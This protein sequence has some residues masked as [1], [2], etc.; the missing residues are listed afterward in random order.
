MLS[1][2]CPHRRPHVTPSLHISLYLINVFHIPAIPDV[3]EE[4]PLLSLS[5]VPSAVSPSSNPLSS[6]P[7][8]HPR[9]KSSVRM[10]AIPSCIPASRRPWLSPSPPCSLSLIT[11]PQ[12]SAGRTDALPFTRGVYY[13]S[14]TVDGVIVSFAKVAHVSAL[15]VLVCEPSELSRTLSEEQF[16]QSLD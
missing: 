2:F 6:P 14:S 8:F 13:Y 9:C 1:C 5:F 15:S 10:P 4:L 7:S 12:P 16:R 3:T 11:T